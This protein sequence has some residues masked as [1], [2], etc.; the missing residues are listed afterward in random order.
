MNANTFLVTSNMK[1]TQSLSLLSSMIPLQDT[2]AKRML[3]TLLTL[4]TN[5]IQLLCGVHKN[6]TMTNPL[7]IC[8]CLVTALKCFKHTAPSCL[9][10]SL[11]PWKGSQ[12]SAT[13]QLTLPPDSSPPL[14]INEHYTRFVH[15][16]SSYIQVRLHLHTF[17]LESV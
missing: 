11:H 13:M 10:N 12:Y 4:C 2:S 7:V 6:K 5:I 8:L 16:S 15:Y 3:C 1:H 14:N 17:I 9:Q